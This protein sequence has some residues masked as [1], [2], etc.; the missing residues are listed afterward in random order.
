[1][2]SAGCVDMEAFF[3]KRLS[4]TN[5]EFERD[6]CCVGMSEASSGESCS[7]SGCKTLLPRA[8]EKTSAAVG[9]RFVGR[10]DSSDSG[11]DLGP[12]GERRLTRACAYSADQAD[13]PEV[14]PEAS[15]AFTHKKTGTRTQ[16]GGGW[17]TPGASI[18]PTGW[19][20]H[21]AVGRPAGWH[22]DANR[23]SQATWSLRA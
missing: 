8:N 11:D 14:Q 17:A 6:A 19:L 3:A 18:S 20:T 12:Q 23:V 13:R 22:G 9:L 21:Q 1:M 15:A 5:E 16:H 4:W 7:A 10:C 2:S